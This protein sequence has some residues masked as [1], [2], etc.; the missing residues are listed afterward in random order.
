[1][2]TCFRCCRQL[3]SFQ[4]ISV[5]FI[6]PLSCWW[7]WTPQSDQEIEAY[8]TSLGSL[9]QSLVTP[10]LKNFLPKFSLN[11][12]SFS[13]KPTLLVLLLSGHIKSHSPSCLQAV[14]KHWED[15][16]TKRTVMLRNT[17]KMYLSLSWILMR[18]LNVFLPICGFWMAP[19]SKS[20]VHYSSKKQPFP[21]YLQNN[22]N[23]LC[24]TKGTK[25]LNSCM[26]SAKDY[27]T[28]S[29]WVPKANL[30]FEIGFQ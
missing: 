7:S 5:T 26:F 22:Q 19:R 11:L 29:Y 17:K 30:I 2:K 1:M 21:Q 8:K 18:T 23:Q 16:C 13:L 15:S 3:L 28:P 9:C 10:W 24:I 4:V 20:S 12:P 14:F 27:L 6:L 25:T